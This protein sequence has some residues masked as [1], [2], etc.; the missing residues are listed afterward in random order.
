[1]DENIRKGRKFEQVLQGART[2]FMKDGFEGA[3]VDDIAK[4]AEVSKATL[5]SYFPD[6]RLLFAE[7]ARSECVRQADH[8]MEMLNP[9][10]APE[11]ALRVAGEHLISFLTSEFGMA[12]L[13]LCAAESRR[14]PELGQEFYK[15]GPLLVRERLVTYLKKAVDLGK[16][17]ITD[18][19][20]AADQF[21]ELC[22]CSIFTRQLCGV[23]T[24]FPPEEL[25][26]ILNGAIEMFMARYSV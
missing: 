13:S 6:K 16:L 5:Y 10:D 20:L 3:S 7:V 14:F 21:S 24:S 26:R 23:Q 9:D 4:V 15:S 2:V 25:N 12:V 22:K 18:F 1:M 11:Q 19:E 17:D 8:A